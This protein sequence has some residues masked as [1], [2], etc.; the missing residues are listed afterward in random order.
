MGFI[1]QRS[2]HWGAPSCIVRLLKA[3]NP[4]E[5]QKGHH[6]AKFLAHQE[7]PQREIWQTDANWC[8]LGQHPFKLGLEKK[9]G[10]GYLKNHA[11]LDPTSS[12]DGNATP[13]AELGDRA[14]IHLGSLGSL[15]LLAL[16]FSASPETWNIL[17]QHFFFRNPTHE[18]IVACQ[19]ARSSSQMIIPV[20]HWVEKSLAQR[21]V[22]L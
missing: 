4:P 2:H 15:Q 8:K 10:S 22:W 17:T 9:P 12:Q 19:V 14:K 7:V 18:T 6:S 20:E 13:M 21:N 11:L 1:N 5:H 3:P 16:K